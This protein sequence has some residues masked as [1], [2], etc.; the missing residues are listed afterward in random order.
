[1]KQNP[2]AS[3]E[4]N[5]GHR[6]L[7]RL[8][9]A[10]LL[11]TVAALIARYI[12]HATTASA[13]DGRHITLATAFRGTFER[14]ITGD[15]IVGARLNQTFTAAWNGVISF[16][17]R[18]GDAVKAGEVLATIE[19]LDLESRLL[20]ERTQ[21][22]VLVTDT[23]RAEVE[24]HKQREL[25]HDNYRLAVVAHEEAARDLARQRRAFEMGAYAEIDVLK[26]EDALR[27]AQI[28][29]ERA[30]SLLRLDSARLQLEER[31]R[32]L[33]RERQALLVADLERHKE[34]LRIRSSVSGQ[35]AQ[36]FVADH[37][38]VLRDTPLINVVDLSS[39][40]LDLKLPETAADEIQ[41]GSKA[42]VT[43]GP[44]SY[45]AQVVAISPEIVG[46][47]VLLRLQFTAATPV[48]LRQGQ[49]LPTRLVLERH[50]DVLMV[51]RGPFLE[52][53][54]GRYAYVVHGNRA[55]RRPIQIAA[56]NAGEVEVADGLRAGDAVVVSGLADASRP[57]IILSP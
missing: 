13:I 18:S 8:A 34:Q 4:T 50:P 17:V 22:E 3:D 54:G 15:S 23:K 29:V 36:I 9:A 10:L 16:R 43:S 45:E 12:P 26:G 55:V 30:Q 2:P 31:S 46:D 7:K 47:A 41:L 57:E 19:S 38:A 33:A 40:E 28:E 1:M 49:R 14:D 53:S 44:G 24:E 21:L 5:P 25:N 56:I 32:A 37:S 39:L 48:G 42:S 27:R 11:I 6:W 52:E 20:Q 35:V 51:Q